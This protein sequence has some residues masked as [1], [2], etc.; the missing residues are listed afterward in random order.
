MKALAL[1][2]A[3]FS[4]RV[5]ALKVAEFDV[6][7]NGIYAYN[8]A[9]PGITDARASW[10]VPDQP[11]TR[12]NQK[13]A[14]WIGLQTE[15]S[16]TVLQPVLTW[17]NWAN[18]A[19]G[20]WNISCWLAKIDKR[21]QEVSHKASKYLRVQPGTRLTGIVELLSYRNGIYTYRC[22]FEGHPESE[23]IHESSE[24]LNTA[25]LEYEVHDLKAC[26]DFTL[27]N[28][29]IT[30]ISIFSGTKNISSSWKKLPIEDRMKC[31]TKV[32]NLRAGSISIGPR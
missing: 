4:D 13:L 29:V 3:F 31:G 7:H 22:V 12:N 11:P 24:Y 9:S 17:G 14:V 30:D 8:P 28:V 26:N 16:N 23:Y 2:F 19:S 27:E 18:G 1:F 5:F 20:G 25:M 15:D 10:V 21:T 32:R 6:Q